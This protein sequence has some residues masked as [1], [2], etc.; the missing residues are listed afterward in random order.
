MAKILKI[1]RYFSIIDLDNVNC[2][3]PEGISCASVTGI[4]ESFYGHNTALPEPQDRDIYEASDRAI[5]YCFK[6]ELKPVYRR[7]RRDYRLEHTNF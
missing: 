2:I 3:S 6:K 7:K 4:N 5:S 1:G